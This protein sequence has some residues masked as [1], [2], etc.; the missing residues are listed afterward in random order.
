MVCQTTQQCCVYC[1]TTGYGVGYARACVLGYAC[2]RMTTAGEAL[3]TPLGYSHHKSEIWLHIK[4]HGIVVAYRPS[5]AFGLGFLL[6]LNP[7]AHQWRDMFP[8]ELRGRKIDTA[9]ACAHI[10]RLCIAAGEYK[11][12]SSESGLESPSDAPSEPPSEP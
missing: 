11:P 3:F 4:T 5:Q 1:A 2:A 6:S 10:T 8:S 12:T 7:D 9:G